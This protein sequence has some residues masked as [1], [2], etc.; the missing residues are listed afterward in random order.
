MNPTGKA[1]AAVWWLD[2]KGARWR[3]WLDV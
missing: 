3:Q 2:E 1:T